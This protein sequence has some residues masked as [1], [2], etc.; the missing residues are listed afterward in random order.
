MINF[1]LRVCRDSC[2]TERGL[3]RR[4][5]SEVWSTLG[6]ASKFEPCFSAPVPPYAGLPRQMQLVSHA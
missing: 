2:I 6:A 4:T 5:R 1:F 3:T